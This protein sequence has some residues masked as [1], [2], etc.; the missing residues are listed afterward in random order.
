M[1]SEHRGEVACADCD[2]TASCVSSSAINA[3]DPEL[4]LAIRS[5]WGLSIPGRIVHHKS[6]YSAEIGTITNKLNQLSWQLEPGE[7]Q[8]ATVPN[9]ARHLCSGGVWED[10][11]ATWKCASMCSSF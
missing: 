3:F 7:G 6:K 9:S 4:S 2:Q 8:P 1:R 11:A 10:N 5:L